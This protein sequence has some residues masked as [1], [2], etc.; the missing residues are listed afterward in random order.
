MIKHLFIVFL[1]VGQVVFSQ[2][3]TEK[4]YLS[5]KDN[6]STIEWDFFCTG[7]RNSGEWTKI[8]VPSCWEQQG[9]GNYDYGRSYHTYGR[10]F[11]FSDEK[12]LYKHEFEIPK[13]WEG[14]T[15]EIV[16]EA[17][18]TDTEVKVNG[19]IAG[20]IH[21]GSF[22]LF[23]YDISDKLKYGES[24]LLE[25]KVSKMSANKMVNRA[26]R[27]ADYWIFGG[28]FR[29]V[30]LEVSPKSH[31]SHTA[32]AAE[33]DG[34][35]HV[36]VDVNNAQKGQML[37]MN[38]LDQAGNILAKEKLKLKKDVTVID[39]K[40]KT[41]NI[42]CWTAETPSLYQAQFRLI[43]KDG[44]IHSMSEKFGFRTVDVKKG[45]GIFING[46]PVKLKGINRHAFWPETGRTLNADL[47]LMDVKLIKEMNMNAIRCSHYPPDQSFLNIC[48]SLGLYVID[49]LAG[50][51]NAY[52]TEV[53]EKLVKEM[54][55]R[56]I[57]HPS[58]VFWS[59]GNEGGTNP[60]LDDDFAKYDHSSRVLIRAHHKPGNAINGIDCN[61][62]EDYYS[63]KEII[64]GENIYMPTE[65][66][67]CQDD[68][69]GGAGLHD[70]WE[71]M[72][73]SPNSGG[74]FLW[75]FSDEAIMRTDMN[76]LL[77]ANRVNAN[78]GVFG[79][80]REKEGS[81]YAIRE[82]YSPIKIE[83]NELSKDFDGKVE[84]E[85]RYFHTNLNVCIF[86]VQLISF[87][88]PTQREKGVSIINEY[89]VD[90]P[91]IE[92]WNKGVID[93][94]INKE[95][96]QCDAVRLLAFDPYGNEVAQWAWKNKRNAE[97]VDMNAK[98]KPESKV[99]VEETDE[100]V[101]MKAND[102]TLSIS[103]SDGTISAID[104]RKSPSISFNN[105]PHLVT[106]EASFVEIKHYDEGE[107]HVVEAKYDGDLKYIKWIMEPNGWVTLDYEYSVEGDVP[108]AGVTFSYP[109]SH[110]IS[111]KWLGEGPSRVWKNRLY[112][113]ETSV[114]ENLYN[115][116]QTGISPWIYP[117]FKGY[118]A[119]ISWMV[120]NTAEGNILMVS[121]D[122][123]LFVRLFDFTGLSDAEVYPQLPIG[124]ISFL[125]AIPPIGT[126][127][128]TG[129]KT[130]ASIY[131]PESEMN[132]LN[133]TQKRTLHFYFGMVTK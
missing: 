54:V 115:N 32:I 1:I 79:P 66:L 91:N 104:I 133:E 95:L 63:T 47:D 29:P 84:V 15:I 100:V 40:G 129:L 109:E 34:S 123:D 94:K 36:K 101:K 106:G 114:W 71:L 9:F 86:K 60:E 99:E 59:N 57:N 97:L 51:Q 92:P 5:G 11:K 119:D 73:N 69:G 17:S 22:Y 53:G 16:F 116:T 56:D 18:M 89:K 21:Q 88:K 72:Y 2:N 24:N 26:E 42:K 82:I 38:I 50:W 31:I 58:I 131:G 8:I 20:P 118:F 10:K 44:L 112:G 125:D 19:Q 126:K 61:H 98:T 87:P 68:G 43:G 65:F 110:I 39:I 77:D 12:G 35:Y 122:K 28:I 27:Y 64:D 80:H 74:G 128:S 45:E 120:L 30:Y 81:F 111:A 75:V 3:S 103:K 127:M 13:S 14:K 25:V 41:G 4:I 78:D 107:N 48:D 23:K 52:D 108:F 130:D 96:T 105:G 124:D 33:A 46:K 121:E 132:H 83:L 49:E 117:E 55:R 6:Q 113:G 102:I 70:Y 85:N 76:N 93:L 90:A 7:G 67:H 62:Y 37:E